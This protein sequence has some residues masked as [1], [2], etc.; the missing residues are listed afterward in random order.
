MDFVSG[1]GMRFLYR[2]FERSVDRSKIL[3]A[4]VILSMK[5]S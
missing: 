4:L 1:I 3:S 2:Y 5:I